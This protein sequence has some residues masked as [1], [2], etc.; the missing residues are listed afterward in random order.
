MTFFDAVKASTSRCA[1]R[2]HG[3]CDIYRYWDGKIEMY[4]KGARRYWALFER[5]YRDRADTA[6]RDW[7]PAV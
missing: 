3:G 6:Q 7:E 2:H 4:T 5:L 1:V